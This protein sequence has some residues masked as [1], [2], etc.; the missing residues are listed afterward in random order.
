MKAAD[1]PSV[2]FVM[3]VETPRMASYL[4]DRAGTEDGKPARQQPFSDPVQIVFAAW[5]AL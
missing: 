5:P 2:S 4:H 3:K 1:C